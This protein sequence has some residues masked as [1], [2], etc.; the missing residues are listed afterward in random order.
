MQK[1][2]RWKLN[3]AIR[4]PVFPLLG[5]VT[6]CILENTMIEGLKQHAR[7]TGARLMVVGLPYDGKFL[8]PG[9]LA[10]GF[11]PKPALFPPHFME[12]TAV[13][14]LSLEPEQIL[15]A[16]HHSK[17]KNI[18][19]ALKRGITVVER[20]GESLM[21]FYK[22]MCELCQRRN[23]TPNP[24]MASFFVELWR[25][26]QPKG[27]IRLFFA[28]N[29]SE[30]VTAA[31]AFSFGDWF[32]VWKIGWSGRHGNLKPNEALWWQMI[33]RARQEGYRF[34]DFVEINPAEARHIAGSDP[35]ENESR[36]ETVT[37][38]KLGFGAKSLFLPGAYYY[39]FNPVLRKLFRVG[40]GR[41]LDSPA[42]LKIASPFLSKTFRI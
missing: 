12:A 6:S 41:W 32:R 22:L 23:T 24:A 35:G 28:M 29:G 34:F 27:W 16:M 19:Q 14:D 3:S 20:D 5:P 8:E 36:S 7:S 33:L 18:R 42:I 31:V 10:S 26:F 21:V 40:A 25:S 13:I 37:A 2:V 30:P 17:R 1:T 11:R 38:F 15:S 39:V 9:L 4:S